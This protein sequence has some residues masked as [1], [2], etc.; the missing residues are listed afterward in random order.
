MKLAFKSVPAALAIGLAA[1]ASVASAAVLDIT[2]LS[3]RP[4]LISGGDALVQITA[5]SAGA[6]VITLNGVNV[7]TMFRAGT[8]AN[9]LVGLVT[10]LNIGANTLAAGGK[11]LVITNYS[12]KGPIISGPYVQPF[13]C[14]TATFALPGG[15]T[16]GAPTD[17]DCSA[18]TKIIY[19][20]MPVGGTALVPLPSM[21][22][23]PADVATTITLNNE[24]VPF[25]VRLETGT[26]DRG[27]Y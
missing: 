21:T 3:N 22:S 20:Y 25:V 4:N 26:M 24:T 23:L 18:P 2:T 12:I 15:T 6:G 14:T 13:I 1:C 10:G 7:T 17:A 16:L 11:S 19:L 27:I 9:T 8:T 5:D